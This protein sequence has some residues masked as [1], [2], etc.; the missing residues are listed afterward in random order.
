MNVFPAEDTTQNF[1]HLKDATQFV[2]GFK[3]VDHIVTQWESYLDI[4]TYIQEYKKD[5]NTRKIT[6][7]KKTLVDLV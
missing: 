4:E 1:V 7:G 6:K 3:T 5:L 2:F